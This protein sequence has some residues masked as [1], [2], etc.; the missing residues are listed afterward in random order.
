MNNTI[1]V[2]HMYVDDSMAGNGTH[3][4]ASIADIERMIDHFRKARQMWTSNALKT[5][6][7]CWVELFD[8]V[9]E[10]LQCVRKG[11]SIWQQVTKHGGRYHR[12]QTNPASQEL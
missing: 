3:Y 9:A 5:S 8:A 1:P 10:H 7:L 6:N 2:A 11:C 4:K 12:R